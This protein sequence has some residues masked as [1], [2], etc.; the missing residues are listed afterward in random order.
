MPGARYIDD[1]ERIR[2]NVEIDPETGCWNWQLAL[3]R[4]GYG[5]LHVADRT[6]QAHRLSYLSIVGPVPRGLVLDHLC[7]N[8]RCANPDHL[9]PVTLL[10]NARRGLYA[11]QTHCRS[12][13]EFTAEN[14]YYK[15]NG[16]RQCRPCNR[17]SAARY[18]TRR[19][20]RAAG[21]AA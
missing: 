21:V 8:R 12:G 3:S 5:I 10:E 14:T 11:Q 20:L 7:R 18:R 15:S 9:E 16:Q 4:D 1:A 17:E 6:V 2:R 19:A 13:H